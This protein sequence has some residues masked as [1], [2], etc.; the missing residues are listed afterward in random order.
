MS[1]AANW[2]MRCAFCA[3]G[4]VALMAA[5]GA[6]QVLLDK[7]VKAGDLTLFP[8]VGNPQAYRYLPDQLRLATN[9]SGGPDFMFQRWVENVRTGPQDAEAREGEG[10]GILRG[11]VLLEVTENQRRQAERELQRVVSGAKIVGPLIYTSGAFTVICATKDPTE[12]IIKSVVGQGPAPILDGQKAAFSMLLTKKGA[13]ILWEQFDMASPDVTFQFDM[14]LDGYQSPISAR[15][16]ADLQSVANHHAFGLGIASKYLEADIRGALS[17][18]ARDGT[19]KVTQIGT[20]TNMEA[21]LKTAYDMVLNAMF[22]PARGT[23]VPSFDDLARPLSSGGNMLDRASRLLSRGQEQARADNAAARRD[24]GSPGGGGAVAPGG[25]TAPA[26]GGGGTRPSA[27]AGEPGPASEMTTSSGAGEEGAEEPAEDEA[28][29]P[30]DTTR[31]RDAGARSASETRA[32]SEDPRTIRTDTPATPR[33]E[34]EAAGGRAGSG[35]GR[36]VAGGGATGTSEEPKIAIGLYYEFRRDRL[37]TRL[38]LSLNKTLP[39]TRPMTF[40]Q[41]IGSLRSYK[42]D[43]AYFQEINLDQPL[44]QQ[45]EIV[46]FVDGLNATDFGEYINFVTV[47]MRKRHAAGAIT[48]DEVRIDRR[49]FNAEGNAFKL[50][51]GWKGDNDRRRWLQYEYQTTW[52]FFGGATLQE[53]W[54]TTTV[55]ALAV[56]PP[57]QRRSVNL[58]GDAKALTDAQVRLVTVKLYYDLGGVEQMKQAT[59][60]PTKSETASRI[61]FMLPGDKFGYDYEMTWRLRGNKTVA[62]GRQTSTESTLFVDE[63]PSA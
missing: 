10:G 36:N 13:K 35:R 39:I 21:A 22:Q 45:R 34:R 2:W 49:N 1:E 17:D 46:V 30:R 20:D 28:V 25:T 3:V 56:V 38:D 16:E 61:D 41:N 51:Y 24:S 48:D 23:G 33:A 14:V 6:N 43:P 15:L 53:P 54:K 32:P 27:G 52:S 7:P 60:D 57:Y 40:T 50:L 12:G 63:V 62:S 11:S 26:V 8:E 31:P 18:C 59:I 29:R 4:L 5:A 55:G 19:I 42:S 44:Y 47:H 58:E 9:A 37:R